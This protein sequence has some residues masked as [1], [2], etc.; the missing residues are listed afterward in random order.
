MTSILDAQDAAYS[1]TMEVR[2]WTEELMKEWIGP[3]QEA[4]QAMSEAK[5]LAMWD[6]MPEE[7]KQ[8]MEAANPE[9]YAKAMQKMAEIR[10]KVKK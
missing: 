6:A 10:K 7:M 4:R 3:M 5:M 2:E 1:A 9:Q 8:A